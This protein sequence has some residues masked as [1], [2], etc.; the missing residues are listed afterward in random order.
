MHAR[1]RDVLGVP[2]LPP[3]AATAATNRVRGGL[4][5]L[6]G[7][8]APPPVRILEALF[9]ALDHRVVTVLC[10]AGVPEALV[11]PCA[12]A[13][14]AA[15]LDVDA[16][17][18]DRLLRYGATRGWVRFDRRGRV[19]PT[20]V[21]RF[22]R[23]DHPGGWR[24]WVDFADGDEVWGAMRSLSVRPGEDGFAVANGEP[25][26]TWMARHPARWA[27][28]DAAMAAG[29]RMH[30][31]AL[32]TA[33]DWADT[34]RVCDVGGGSG[35]LLV[36]LLDLVPT[37][38]GAVLDLPDVVARAQ[39]H[40]RLRAVGGD[41][42]DDVPPGFDT[43]LLVNVLH[44]WPDDDAVR[45]LTRVAVALAG[46]EGA[47]ARPE[48]DGS[49]PSGRVVVVDSVRRDPPRADLSVQADVLM[50]ALTGGG[51]ERTAGEVA[52]LAER[53]GLRLA[54]TVPLASGDVAH[55]LR[56]ADA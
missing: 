30:A 11:A 12:P 4:R 53:C 23:S 49:H 14:L 50:A 15:R 46:P 56:A 51:R 21:T 18:L 20:R 16:S 24:A 41:A 22:L 2:F 37:I 13:E 36:T 17:R 19:R 33:L 26:F 27:T 32:A 6:V 31:L 9:G 42:F 1:P 29:A 25:F 44:D 52:A 8:L 43:Y 28:F 39:P 10:A 45:L 54:R 47:V 35:E 48:G 34:R 40:A 38:E 55:E 5:R 7:G 3:P